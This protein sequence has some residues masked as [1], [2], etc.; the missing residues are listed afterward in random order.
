MT[1][2]EN[3]RR[4]AQRRTCKGGRRSR[5]QLASKKKRQACPSTQSTSENYLFL[6]TGARRR[7]QQISA[8]PVQVGEKTSA[9]MNGSVMRQRDSARMVLMSRTESEKL[10]PSAKISTSGFATTSSDCDTCHL[11]TTQTAVEQSACC[12]ETELAS[13]LVPSVTFCQTVSG[14][15][16]LR[17]QLEHHT[18]L[19]SKG[20]GQE[21]A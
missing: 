21:S 18:F 2:D 10:Q 16:C 4:T 17:R 19:C 9:S 8:D 20:P 13:V 6:E 5:K 15:H 12:L 14:P 11:R 1:D 3:E 7:G